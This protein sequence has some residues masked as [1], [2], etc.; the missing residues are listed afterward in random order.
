MG[1]ELEKSVIV[2]VQSQSH[3][4]LFA[5]SLTLACQAPLSFIISWS[6]LKFMSIG[7]VMLSNHLI[8]CHSLYPFAC[9]LSQHQSLFQIVSWSHQVAKVL[10]FQLQKQTFQ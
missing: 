2:V 6:W 7:S 8:L 1:K 5:T 4:P 10:E 9:N 3:V